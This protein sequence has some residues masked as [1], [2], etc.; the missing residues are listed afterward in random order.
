MPKPNDDT[1]NANLAGDN[2]S[3]T[4]PN[5]NATGGVVKDNSQTDWAKE[6]IHSEKQ[7]RELFAW[8]VMLV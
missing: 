2:T 4:Q 8:A 1:Q 6:L 7:R 5:N 3:S